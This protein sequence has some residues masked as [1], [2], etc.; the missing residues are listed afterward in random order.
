VL[1]GTLYLVGGLLW[2]LCNIGYGYEELCEKL[3]VHNG[4]NQRRAAIAGVFVGGAIC[5]IIWPI[6][7]LVTIAV[8]F[9]R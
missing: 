5:M 7:L 6:M 9:K 1:A 3:R 8:L 2:W 4:T